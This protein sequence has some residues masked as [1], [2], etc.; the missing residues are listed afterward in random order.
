MK[1]KYETSTGEIACMLETKDDISEQGY[2]VSDVSFGIPSEPLDF[3]TFNGSELVRKSQQVID[4][5]VAIKNFSFKTMWGTVWAV[6]SNSAR[7]KLPPYKSTIEDLWFYPNRSAIYP[8]IQ[9]LIEEGV[10]T[11]DDLSILVGAFQ[12]QGIDIVTIQ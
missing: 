12:A 4:Q 2:S 9:A 11:Q 5:I 8:Y 10:G 7:V 3:F 1:I 6:L